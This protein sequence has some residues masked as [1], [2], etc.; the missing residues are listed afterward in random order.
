MNAQPA[1]AYLPVSAADLEDLCEIRVQA[2]Q[3]SLAR[4]GRFDD[5]RAR[6]RL[7]DQFQP[8]ATWLICVN[9]ARAGFY[10]LIRQHD[11]F[12]LQNLY[13]LPGMSGQGLGSAVLRHI[14]AQAD[15]A[16]LPVRLEV[17]IESD[18]ARFY[19]RH[20][21]VKLREEGV[22][23]YYQRAAAILQP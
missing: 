19:E 14:L 7:R 12:Y 22:D 20:G 8:G 6:Q 15:A 4:I 23:L 18:A 21:F 11:A 5:A 13:L 10:C 2:M 9:G 16:S 17:L 1:L 3:P